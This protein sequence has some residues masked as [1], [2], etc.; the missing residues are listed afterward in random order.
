MVIVLIALLGLFFMRG[1][2]DMKS[3][4]IESET[5]I[6]DDYGDDVVLFGEDKKRMRDE[7]FVDTTP[8][9][10]MYSREN[11]HPCEKWWLE[12]RPKW[13]SVGWSIEKIMVDASDKKLTPRFE[14]HD[15]DG[16][17]FEVVGFMTSYTFKKAKEGKK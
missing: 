17:T 4:K 5:A 14:I 6:V 3:T 1:D 10:I 15:S 16:Q 7:A 9:I 2:L 8:R 11:C 12:E 13:E